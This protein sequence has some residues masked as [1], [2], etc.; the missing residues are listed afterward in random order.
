MWVN[1]G[2]IMNIFCF[3]QREREEFSNIIKS[4]HISYSKKPCAK[5]YTNRKW[6]PRELK[7]WFI[8]EVCAR[9]TFHSTRCDMCSKSECIASHI[10]SFPLKSAFVCKLFASLRNLFSR[11]F[12]ASVINHIRI[13]SCSHPWRK[14]TLCFPQIAVDYSS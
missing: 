3:L 4:A 9:L 8:A 13:T 12:R 1:Y 6:F 2:D 11:H 5:Y 10:S 7:R 14:V